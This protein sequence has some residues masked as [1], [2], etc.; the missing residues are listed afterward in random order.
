M[1]TQTKPSRHWDWHCDLKL[2]QWSRRV[3]RKY[4]KCVTSIKTLVNVLLKELWQE[5]Q[6]INNF[7][8]LTSQSDSDSLQS[9]GVYED[10][11]IL[12]VLTT[13]FMS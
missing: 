7:N 6:S 12:S 4:V 3:D 13:N 1:K 9:A 8:L 2:Y 10:C 5:E 11:L